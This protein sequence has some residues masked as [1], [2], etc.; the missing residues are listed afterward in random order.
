M[1]HVVCRY[2]QQKYEGMHEN[3]TLQIHKSSD[4]WEGQECKQGPVSSLKTKKKIG[5][6]QVVG[7]PVFLAITLSTFQYSLSF[8]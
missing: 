1:L 5:Q 2:I 6:T 8:L 7:I 4:A 3:R